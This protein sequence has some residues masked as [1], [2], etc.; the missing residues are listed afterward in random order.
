M[1]KSILE[2]LEKNYETISLNWIAQLEL[3]FGDRLSKT[4]I[5][6]FTESSL[7]S[8]I[9]VINT[10]DYL[11]I[12]QSLIDRDRL[13]KKLE[14][15]QQYLNTILLKSDTAI[16]VINCDEKFVSWNHG[17]E[18]M[19]GYS[20]E[21]VIGQSS[22]FLIPDE[23]K[24]FKELEYIIQETKEKGDVQIID[25]ERKTK[26][27]K[28]ISVQ[29]KV[30]QLQTSDESNCGRTMIMQ[31]ITQ[32]KQLQQQVDQ[33]EKLAVIGQLA[34]GIAHE[35]GNPLT[36]I[37]AVVQ[38]IQRKNKDEIMTEQLIT[39]KDNI[40]RISNIVNEL[41]DFSRPP[42]ENKGLLQINDVVKTAVGIVKYDKRVKK[43]D[44]KTHFAKNLSPVLAV[45]DQLLQVYVNI[46][47]N[48]LDAINGEGE[49]EVRTYFTDLFICTDIKDNGCGMERSLLDK[50]FNPFFTTKGVGKGTGLGLSVSYGIIK[51]M[52]GKIIVQSELN[53]GSVFTIKLLP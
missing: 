23:E 38:L 8:I 36:S 42:G 48:A 10:S 18:E 5:K 19:F 40:D 15:N 50:I 1:K 47:L 43:V 44:F 9:E 53:K 45:P 37:S 28:I 49:I 41:V 32:I 46:L 11:S 12:D 27:G 30:T 51:K 29:L 16:A 21:E 7:Q 26:S 35:I 25:T 2:L 3:N 52:Q 34:A 13:E 39:I 33:S 6:E 20:A 4:E 24:Y 17:A 14:M 31:D 22:T